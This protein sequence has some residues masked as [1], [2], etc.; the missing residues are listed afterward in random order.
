MP[1]PPQAPMFRDFGWDLPRRGE[2]QARVPVDTL[3][4]PAAG[5]RLPRPPG[6]AKPLVEL[7]AH[8]DYGNWRQIPDFI[9]TCVK[10]C[11]SPSTSSRWPPSSSPRRRRRGAGL[12]HVSGE[13]L[14]WIQQEGDPA[15]FTSRATR[16]IDADNHSPVGF[17]L[18]NH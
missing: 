13:C 15:F 11:M 5:L 12:L 18:F 14:P 4:M 3:L 1:P 2:A 8:D 7:E 17:L 6:S 10:K 16:V 9:G